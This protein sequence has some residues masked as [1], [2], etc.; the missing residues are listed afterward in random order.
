MGEEEEEEDNM[1]PAHANEST[2][3]GATTRDERPPASSDSDRLQ[4]R[5]SAAKLSVEDKQLLTSALSEIY[6]KQR[7]MTLSQSQLL[8]PESL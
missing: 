2:A 6:E 4:T 8:I 5:P 1:E 7:E 3:R